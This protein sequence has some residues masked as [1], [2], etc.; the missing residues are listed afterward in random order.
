MVRPFDHRRGGECGDLRERSSAASSRSSSIAIGP[1]AETKR[2]TRKKWGWI[3]EQAVIDAMRGGPRS[4]GVALPDSVTE[5]LLHAYTS[6]GLLLEGVRHGPPPSDLA[7]VYMHGVRSSVFRQGHV[8]V[9]RELGAAGYT[10]IAGNNRGSGLA[11]P[12]PTRDGVRLGGAWFERLEDAAE[13]LDAWIDL[14]LASG[15]R[16]IVL[17]GHSLGAVKALLYTSARP[18]RELV[19]LILASPPL[20]GFAARPGE[21]LL[22]RAREAVNAGRP[23]EL[24]DLG[25]AGLTFGRLSAAT[26]LSRSLVGDPSGLLVTTSCPVLAMYGTDEAAVGGES[27]LER[28]RQ[29][30]PDRFTGAMIAGA[31][32]LYSGHERDVADAITR[33]IDSAVSLR[34]AAAR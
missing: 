23:Q 6:D 17:L 1:D 2:E 22:A 34:P 29:V 12:L 3:L 33:W 20:R 7:I 30:I 14:A 31:N 26:I 27:D 21:D 32:H 5:E 24:V 13:D 11:T 18:D 28:L 10:V 4:G 8:R 25:T 19:G 9:G 15:A 16:R